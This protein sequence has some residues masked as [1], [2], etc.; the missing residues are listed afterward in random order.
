MHSSLKQATFNGTH[1]D[2]QVKLHFQ[3]K[4]RDK[5]TKDSLLTLL[6]YTDLLHDLCASK[7]LGRDKV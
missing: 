5:R 3:N 7:D 1:I 2:E 4:F 6:L